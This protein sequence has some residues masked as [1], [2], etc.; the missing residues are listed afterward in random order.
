VGY[1][2]RA[3]TSAERRRQLVRYTVSVFVATLAWVACSVAGPSETKRPALGESFSVSVGESAQIE[4]E[5]LQIG[6]EDVSGDSRCPKG[7]RCIWEGD[8]TVRV[9]L[10]K[11]PGPKETR[12]LHT[13]SK[14]QGAV[15]YLGYA[16]KLLRLDPYPVSG[17]TIERGEYRA[18][19][20]VTRGSSAP[21]DSRE[22]LGA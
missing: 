14:E 17:K 16:V 4:G 18:T 12:E 11:A 8:T 3:T 21:P 19:L 2:R 20:E 10:Q 9:W 6:F 13:S 15:S 1:N 22:L 5:G 7:E